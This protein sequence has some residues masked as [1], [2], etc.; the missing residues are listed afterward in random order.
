MGLRLLFYHYNASMDMPLVNVAKTRTSEISTIPAIITPIGD[1]QQ[2]EVI[3]QTEHFIRRGAA[4]FNQHF[5]E[6][7]VV[8]DLRGCAAGMYK[9]TGRKKGWGIGKSATQYRQIRYNPWVFAKYYQE[10]LTVTVPHEVAHY[11]VDC[12]HGLRRVRPHGSEWKAVMDAFGVDDSV[13]ARFDLAGIP[14]RKHQQFDYRCDCKTHQL[15]IRRH[16][17]ILRGQACYIC[18][19]CGAALAQVEVPV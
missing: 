16:S 17:K 5:A 8:F 2:R 15:G 19:Y 13:A 4:L 6:V 7:P 12:L 10:N 1:V 9:V 14:V 3:E 11:L 18:R